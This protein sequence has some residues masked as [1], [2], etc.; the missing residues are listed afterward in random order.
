M[1][2]TTRILNTRMSNKQV[3]TSVPTAPVHTSSNSAVIISENELES[4]KD[5]CLTNLKILSKIRQGDKLLYNNRTFVIDAWSYTQP[6]YRWYYSESRDTT[7]KNLED[8]TS[9]LLKTIDII[10]SNEFQQPSIE[11]NYYTQVVST[12]IPAFKE[13][14]SN[15]LLNFVTEMKNALE[16]LSNLKQTYKDDISTVSGIDVLIEKISVRIKKIS[17]ILSIDRNVSNTGT[18]NV[19]VPIPDPIYK[20]NKNSTNQSSNDTLHL[21]S[22]SSKH[23]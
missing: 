5:Y 1:T 16:G 22:S 9:V 8:F 2:H 15:M 13:E 7:V 23:D 3:I 4:T 12:S 18:S 20:K 14:N 6:L 21:S 19:S 11:N 10:Y 17:N